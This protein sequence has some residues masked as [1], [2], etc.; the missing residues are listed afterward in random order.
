M[1]LVEILHLT[2]ALNSYQQRLREQ[3]TLQLLQVFLNE[4][5]KESIFYNV[6]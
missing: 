3:T 5:W 1:L 2:P 4:I 6:Y